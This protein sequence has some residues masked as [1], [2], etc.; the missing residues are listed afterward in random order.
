M[1]VLV[2]QISELSSH[3]GAGSVRISFGSAH[4][5]ITDLLK[6]GLVEPETLKKN[7]CKGKN[8]YLSTLKCILGKSVP[9]HGYIDY[10][11]Q[12][13]KNSKAEIGVFENQSDLT[14]DTKTPETDDHNE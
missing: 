4:H 6:K 14:E 5:I 11:Q 7:P 13:V 8:T 10:K 2:S 1:L 12:E 3:Q 9:T